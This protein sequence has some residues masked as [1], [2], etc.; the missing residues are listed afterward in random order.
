MNSFRYFDA[1]RAFL[2]CGEMTELA[3]GARLEIVCAVTGT[4]GSNPFLSA[5]IISGLV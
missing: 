3:E 2:Y 5:I 1:A 4:K